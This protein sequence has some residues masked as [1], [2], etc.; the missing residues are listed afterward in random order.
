MNF[1]GIIQVLIIVFTLEV[2]SEMTF[3]TSGLRA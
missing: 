2:N 1:L 3:A